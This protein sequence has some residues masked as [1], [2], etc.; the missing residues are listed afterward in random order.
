M[1]PLAAELGPSMVATT[2]PASGPSETGAGP[3]VGSWLAEGLAGALVGITPDSKLALACEPLAQPTTANTRNDP[4]AALTIAGVLHCL[5]RAGRGR[6]RA[7]VRRA[8][9]RRMNRASMSRSS[10]T[11]ESSDRH[12]HR[13]ARTR[14]TAAIEDVSLHTIGPARWAHRANRFASLQVGVGRQRVGRRDRVDSG[15]EDN[16][17]G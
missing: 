7:R 12:C 13:H 11:A 3:H 2:L 1:L 16:R 9:P 17:T 8:R 10:R 14:V 5:R 6:A 4:E 15:A